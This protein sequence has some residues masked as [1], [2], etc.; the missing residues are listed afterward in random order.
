VTFR[1]YYL[2]GPC[3]HK[4]QSREMGDEPDAQISCGGATYVYTPDRAG[5]AGPGSVG[6]T[7]Y[8]LKGGNL[9]RT[10]PS[11]AGETDVFKAWSRLHVALNRGVGRQSR[12]IADSGR[13]IRRI[14]R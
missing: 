7:P 13:R 2:D 5:E 3:A 1:V 14:V 11:I 9:D 6:L 12:R 8:A 10:A 4:I